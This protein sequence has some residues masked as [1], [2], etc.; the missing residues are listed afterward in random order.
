[1]PRAGKEKTLAKEASLPR[2]N[3][4]TLGKEKTLGTDFFAE[5]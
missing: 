5:S 1:L 3:K 2:A 4:K